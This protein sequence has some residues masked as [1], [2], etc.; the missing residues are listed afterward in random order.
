[1]G[2]AEKG[3]GE[4]LKRTNEEVEKEDKKRNC[5]AYLVSLNYSNRRE[6]KRKKERI[7]KR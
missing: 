4:N 2:L 5:A 7:N 1:M 6:R 3:I